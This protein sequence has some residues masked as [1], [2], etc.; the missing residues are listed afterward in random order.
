MQLSDADRSS[1]SPAEIAAIEAPDENPEASAAEAKQ[2]EEAKAEPKA[3]EQAAAK[4]PTAEE[5]AK[6]EP[7]A[8]AAIPGFF[9]TMKEVPKAELDAS[10]TKLEDAKKKYDEGTLEFDKYDEVRREHDKLVWKAESAVEFNASSRNQAWEYQQ[11]IF[12]AQNKEYEKNGALNRAFVATVNLLMSTPQGQAM[13][14]D[15]I[16]SEAKKQVDTDL[17]LIKKPS[18]DDQQKADQKKLEDDRKKAIGA[19]KKSNSDKSKVGLDIGALPSAS[20]EHDQDEF[21]AIDG[22][23]GTAYMAALELMQK[24]NPAKFA[25][26]EAR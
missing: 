18:G 6:A 19:A 4:T 20:E 25:R 17:G 3:D 10:K 21:A 9:P 16:L 12:F 13:T 11:K 24:T 14:D 5:A 26:Y 7:K 2:Q 22:L 23:E 15:Q 1:L 8:D